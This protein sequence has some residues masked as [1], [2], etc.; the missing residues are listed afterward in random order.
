MEENRQAAVNREEA[1]EE[2]RHNLRLQN[3]A[4]LKEQIQAHAT[5][6]VTGICLKPC[7]PSRKPACPEVWL[8]GTSP[9]IRTER[10]TSVLP[11]IDSLHPSC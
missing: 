2:R 4:A 10:D 6:K 8:Y 3:L 5:A 1:D 9:R 7:L 11:P